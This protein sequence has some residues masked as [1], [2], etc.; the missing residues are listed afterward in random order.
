[1]GQASKHPNPYGKLMSLMKEQAENASNSIPVFE[2]GEM[3]TGAQIK[4][5]SRKLARDDYILLQNEIDVT[6]DGSK[7]RFRLPFKKKTEVEFKAA[8]DDTKGG[9]SKVSTIKITAP[10]L[11]KG[12]KVLVYQMS[13]QKYIVFGK[14]A[15]VDK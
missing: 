12:D 13:S 7:K 10:A 14:V 1:M 11:K 6:V 5:G 8:S 2:V 9:G 3:L 4:L 15:E